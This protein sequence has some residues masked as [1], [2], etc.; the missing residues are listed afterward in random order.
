MVP[1][2]YAGLLAEFEPDGNALVPFEAGLCLESRGNLEGAAT[3]LDRAFGLDPDN[4]EIIDARSRVLDQ[5]SVVEHGLTFRY[6]PA[7]VFLMG[8]NFGEPDERPLRP[9]WLSEYW[10]ADVPI[11][12][13]AYSRLMGWEQVGRRPQQE[14]RDE[15]TF[16]H[17][18]SSKLCWSY[19]TDD[20][21]GERARSYDDVTF[22]TK[23]MVAIG[24]NDATALG[25]RLSSSKVEYGLPTEAQW[26]KAARGG[27]IGQRWPW[28][29]Q[30]A[31]T[32]RCDCESFSRLA[33]R[34][35]KYYPPNSYGLYAMLGGVWEWCS[36]WYDRDYYPEAKSRDPVGPSKGKEKVL[37][38]GAW[39]DTSAV[40]TVSF[41][42]SQGI[43]VG[44]GH[45]AYLTPTIGARLRR[46]RKP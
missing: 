4:P 41:R 7:G 35:S 3:L 26:E 27:R 44:M 24:W 32:D 21:T 39:T 36:D 11:S 18:V 2:E 16:W 1:E 30:P 15:E 19:S 22:E 28:G 40:C 38:G 33:I 14:Q 45:R 37:R 5:L 10:L 9:V 31:S 12:L 25:A 42:A 13:A 46:S 6:V 8:D 23:P 29:D 34:P 17:I 43:K 20:L